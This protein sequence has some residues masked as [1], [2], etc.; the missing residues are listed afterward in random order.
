MRWY[1]KQADGTKTEIPGPE[2]SYQAR[3][4]RTVS[5]VGARTLETAAGVAYLIVGGDNVPA[6]FLFASWSRGQKENEHPQYFFPATRELHRSAP[7][8]HPCV[9]G[10]TSADLCPGDSL[11]SPAPGDNRRRWFILDGVP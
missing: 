6:E 4:G 1:T 7:N 5:L 8:L 10:H 9:L 2:L 11:W 3:D